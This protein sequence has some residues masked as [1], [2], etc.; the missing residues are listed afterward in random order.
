VIRSSKA[1]PVYQANA[2]SD[3]PNPL[4]GSG[5]YWWGP[6]TLAVGEQAEL[7]SMC[8]PAYLPSP[9]YIV[10]PKSTLADALL[11]DNYTFRIQSAGIFYISSSKQTNT[12]CKI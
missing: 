3:E 7:Y 6:L 5:N 10:H 9:R 11:F 2:L 4:K 1:N 12:V 8:L